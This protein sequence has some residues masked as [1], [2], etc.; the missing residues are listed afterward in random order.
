MLNQMQLLKQVQEAKGNA[1]QGH[2]GAELR[3]RET[4]APRHEAHERPTTALP[5]CVVQVCHDG[6][7][8]DCTGRTKLPQVPRWFQVGPLRRIKQIFLDPEYFP[9]QSVTRMAPRSHYRWPITGRLNDNKNLNAPW[10]NSSTLYSE[11]A[12]ILCSFCHCADIHSGAKSV[13]RI[14]DT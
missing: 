2:K 7:V 8:N 1:G 14:T 4:G 6:D 12:W 5:W 9:S 11:V 13:F 10:L 3:I